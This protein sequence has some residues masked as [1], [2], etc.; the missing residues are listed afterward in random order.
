MGTFDRQ[1]HARLRRAEGLERNRQA[2]VADGS[3]TRSDRPATEGT[4][5]FA[6]W[7][8]RKTI[9]GCHRTMPRVSTHRQG[10]QRQWPNRPS[11]CSTRRRRE[12]QTAPGC[13]SARTVPR[14]SPMFG[15]GE[16]TPHWRQPHSKTV[17]EPVRT[18]P[19]RSLEHELRSARCE[20]L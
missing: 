1:R 2:R 5:G 7:S 11:N 3:L 20:P 18:R 10:I 6:R 13:R 9:A 8:V 16:S 17:A 4:P 14:T 15:R 12:T 19:L